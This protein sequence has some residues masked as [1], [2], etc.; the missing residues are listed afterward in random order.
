MMAMAAVAALAAASLT[1]EMWERAR[2]VYEKTLR[3]PFLTGLTDGTL[4]RNR[5]Q[6]YL[7]QDAQYLRVYGQAL[8]VLTVDSPVP[9]ELLASVATAIAADLLREIDILEA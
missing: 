1:G 2:P 7:E 5:F 6:F 9:D 3:H 8:S 4:P